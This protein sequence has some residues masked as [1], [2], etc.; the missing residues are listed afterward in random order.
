[1]QR[2]CPSFIYSLWDVQKLECISVFVLSTDQGGHAPHFQLHQQRT[3]AEGCRPP[4]L[5]SGPDGGPAREPEEQRVEEQIPTSSGT[6]QQGPHSAVM[7]Q[8]LTPW[9]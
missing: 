1:M 4:P 6:P 8:R 3:S 7:A 9:S 5:C 2:P